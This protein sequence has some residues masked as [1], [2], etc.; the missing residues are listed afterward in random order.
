LALGRF[1]PY[2]LKISTPPEVTRQ[3]YQVNLNIRGT[4]GNTYQA[5]VSACQAQ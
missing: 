2:Q 1:V 5:R 3:P 4:L